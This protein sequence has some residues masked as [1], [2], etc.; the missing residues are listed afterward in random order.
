MGKSSNPSADILEK[1]ADYFRVSVSTL[2]DENPDDE[3]D[4]QLIAMFRQLKRLE[5]KDRELI[6]LILE[7][8]KKQ[9]KKGG[10]SD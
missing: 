10:D 7:Q 2:M 3:K 1:L 6:Q 9:E 4:E 8:K 5:P